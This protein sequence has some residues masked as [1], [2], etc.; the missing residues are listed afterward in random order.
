MKK[1][2]FLLACAS[3]LL[4][5]SCKKTFTCECNIVQT[6]PAEFNEPPVES[7]LSSEFEAK[8]LSKAKA[9]CEQD[10]FMTMG[11]MTQ[12]IKCRVK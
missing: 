7:Y 4:L 8:S 11:D 2:T 10:A 1:F 3:M 9:E 12:S 6:F 5:M